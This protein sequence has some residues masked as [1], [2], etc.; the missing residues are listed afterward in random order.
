MSHRNIQWLAIFLLLLT[1]SFTA[2]HYGVH[3]IDDQV[4]IQEKTLKHDG[5]ERTYIVHLPNNVKPSSPCPLVIALHGAGGSGASVMK[6]TGLN[7]LSDRERFIAVYPD[8]LNGRWNDGRSNFFVRGVSKVDDVG[9]ISA[10]I[11]SF[12]DSGDADSN[13]IYVTG[14]SNGGMMAYRLGI[15]LTDKLA[16]IASVIANLPSGLADAKPA[17]SLSVLIMNGTDDPVIPWKGG[18]LSTLGFSYGTVLSTEDTVKFWLRADNLPYKVENQPL[19]DTDSSDQCQVD[20]AYH[21]KPG[22]KV[23]VVLYTIIGGGHNLPGGSEPD[24][25]DILGRKCMDINGPHVIWS[26]FKRHTLAT[27]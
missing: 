25:L 9:F 16:A 6:W 1:P 2:C 5:V 21:R 17:R 8:G 19:A 10:L 4:E 11:D 15:E 24:P 13:R 18:K 27:G 23:E 12:I 3:S 22:R 7:K 20:V 14:I 26:F